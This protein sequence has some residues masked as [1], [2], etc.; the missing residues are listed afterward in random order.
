[1]SK[2]L[3]SVPEAAEIDNKEKRMRDFILRIL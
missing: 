2:V 3:N 1:M